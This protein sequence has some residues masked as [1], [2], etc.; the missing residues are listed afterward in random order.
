MALTYHDYLK[1]D[2]ILGAQECK[3]VGEHDEMLFIVIH[4]VYELWFKQILHEASYL[5]KNLVVGDV[6]KSG[7]A[8]KR[9]LKIMKT[10]VGQIDILETMTP[11]SFSSFR[12]VLDTSSG[13][14]SVQ[15]RQFEIAMG[16]RPKAIL[17]HLPLSPEQRANLMAEF[18]RPS[19]YDNL[20]QCLQV[21]GYEI[22]EDVLKRDYS[23]EYEGNKSVQDVLLGIYRKESSESLLF[24]LFVDLEEGVQE[25][26][27]RHVKMVER[28]IGVKMGTGGSPGVE[29][30]KSTLFKPLFCDLWTIRSLF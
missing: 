9:I 13:F 20:L 21:R 27:Y 29:Y 15:F 18:S 12:N 10:L 30:L 17:S 1:L 26:R 6:A 3:S 22:P 2:N 4:Q 25:W 8:L 14:Q 24:E 28:T 23:I 11:L 5:S 7:H 16:K 19:L